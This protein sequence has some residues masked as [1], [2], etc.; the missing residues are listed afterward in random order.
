M[1]TQAPQVTLGETTQEIWGLSLQ[2]AGCPPCGQVHLLPGEMRGQICPNCAGAEMQPQPAPLRREPPEKM[3]P[4]QVQQAAL[5]A[6][7]GQFARG[8]WLRPNELNPETL[9]QRA[10]PV[11]VPMWL[12]D[13]DLDGSWQAEMGFDYQV[14]SSQ[15]MYAGGNWQTR[16][17]I[18]TRVRWEPRLGQVQIHYDNAAVPAL[19]NHQQ[20]RA[21]VG[22]YK[23][24]SARPYDPRQVGS[25]ALRVPDQDTGQAWPQARDALEAHLSGDCLQA[26]GAQHLRRFTTRID[27]R[28]QNWTQLLLPLYFSWYRDDDGVRRPV[29]VNGQSGQIGGVRLASQ[30]KGW[31]WAGITAAVAV[32]IF[33]LALLGF[34]LAAIFPPAAVVGAVLALIALLVGVGAIVPAVWPWQWNRRQVGVKVRETGG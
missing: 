21:Q 22:A 18:E 19:S 27:Y 3:L 33:L 28:G 34:A 6:I 1:E 16:E 12:V 23:L 7:F 5:Q 32:A 31:Q 14:K 9:L 29:Y 13:S 8:V 15:E 24:A 4:F 25:A 30:R 26:A 2:A 17:K 20:I 10:V 11:Y